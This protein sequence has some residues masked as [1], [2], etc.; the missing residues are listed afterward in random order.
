[1]L[2]A[3]LL[4]RALRAAVGFLERD[5]TLL[6]FGDVGVDRDGA[7]A[8]DLALRDQDPAP[9]GPALQGRRPGIAMLRQTLLNSLANIESSQG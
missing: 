6:Q 7:A 2:A 3:D 4:G 1:M 8:G 5:L 9:V